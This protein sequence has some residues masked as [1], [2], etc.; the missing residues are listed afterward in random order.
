MLCNRID[1]NLPEIES[2]VVAN[3]F[4]LGPESKMAGKLLQLMPLSPI[5]AAHIMIDAD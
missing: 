3:K 1:Y 5:T 2:H 4:L